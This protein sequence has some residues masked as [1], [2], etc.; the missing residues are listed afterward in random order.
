LEYVVAQELIAIKGR[1]DVLGGQGVDFKK[2]WNEKEQVPLVRAS[3]LWG[4]MVLLQFVHAQVAKLKQHPSFYDK[5][6][7][8]F[9]RIIL[10]KVPELYLHGF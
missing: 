6:C 1:I 3:E 4:Y 5:V 2:I 8:A 9:T 7:Q 10:A